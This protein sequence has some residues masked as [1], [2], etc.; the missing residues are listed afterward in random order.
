LTEPPHQREDFGHFLNKLGLVGE[1]AEI[2]VFRGEYSR[3]LL[4]TW[5]GRLLHLID[6]WQHQSDYQDIANLTDEH[7]N[8]CLAETQQNLQRHAGRFRIHRLKSIE[9]AQYFF[10]HSL[11]FVYLD[12]NHSF[13]AVS[14]DLRT[15]FPKLKSGGIFAGHDYLDGRL[16]EGLFGVASAVNEFAGEIGVAISVTREAVWPSWYFIKPKTTLSA[17]SIRYSDRLEVSKGAIV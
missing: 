3:I 2:G 13:A 5:H 14:E 12:A 1:A 9:A 17:E 4:D 10:D 7:F 16:P 6:P 8:R 11:D 15:W